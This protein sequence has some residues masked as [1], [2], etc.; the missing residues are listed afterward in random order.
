MALDVTEL[1]SADQ[2]I[3]TPSFMAP[4]QVLGQP[5]D[6][7]TDLFSLGCVMYAMV[8]GRSPFAG[9]H[10]LDVIRKVC[11]EVPPPLMRSTPGSRS[12]SRKS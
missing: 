10:T 8:T 2:V 11:D 7:R 9:S 6:P 12:H 4:E 1:T 5:V 3:G